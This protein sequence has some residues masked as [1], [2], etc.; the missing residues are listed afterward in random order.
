[1][2][3]A[4]ISAVSFGS[5]ALVPIAALLVAPGAARIPFMAALSLLSLVGLGALGGYLG[6]A[7]MARA[8]ARVTVGGA[9]A[10]AV[11]AAI[12]RLFGVVAG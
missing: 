7:P 8:A 12:G 3:A 1:V 4:W 5:F 2:Q 9:L 10:M 11:T 6:G